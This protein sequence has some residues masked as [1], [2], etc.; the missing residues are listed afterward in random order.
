VKK[1][2][3]RKKSG[4]GSAGIM[5]IRAEELMRMM[6]A[7][8]PY[9]EQVRYGTETWGV[10][11]RMVDKYIVKAKALLHEVVMAQ[12]KHALAEC[13]TELNSIQ[14]GSLGGPEPSYGVARQCVMDK[15]K[16]LGIAVDRVAISDERDEELDDKPTEDLKAGLK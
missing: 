9:R 16:L 14:E 7:G 13:I 10:S 6:V 3:K 12:A 1:K 8:T 15:A 4:K 5:E 11:S 2:A